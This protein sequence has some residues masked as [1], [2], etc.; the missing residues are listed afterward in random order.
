[1]DEISVNFKVSGKYIS[2]IETWHGD[3]ERTFLPNSARAL[4]SYV[5]NLYFDYES[6]HVTITFDTEH[7]FET[8]RSDILSAV[9]YAAAYAA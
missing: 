8:M 6:V 3:T 5:Y 1:M 7:M 9:T 4:M 2:V